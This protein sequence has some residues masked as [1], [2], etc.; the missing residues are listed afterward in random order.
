MPDANPSVTEKSEEL[1]K[2]EDAAAIAKVLKGK[3]D[4]DKAAA[5]AIN[6]KIKAEKEREK[7]EAT[8]GLGLLQAQA[9]AIAKLLPKGEAKPL[10]GKVETKDVGGVA[11]LVAFHVIRNIAVNIAAELGVKLGNG[12]KKVMIV[13]QLDFASG[14]LPLIEIMSQLDQFERLL[15]SQI[16][17]NK[18]I[19]KPAPPATGAKKSLA[20]LP[21]FSPATEIVAMAGTIIPGLANLIGYFKTDYTVTGYEFELDKEALAAGVAGALAKEQT[22]VYFY[23]FYNIENVQTLPVIQKLIQLGNLSLDL[24][25]LKADLISKKNQSDPGAKI[26]ELEQALKESQALLDVIKTYIQSINTK[27]TG[28]DC[29]KLVRAALRDRMH[30]LGITHLLYLNILPKS[31]GESIVKRSI[32]RSTE[33]VGYLGGAAAS[34]VLAEKGGKIIASDLRTGLSLYNYLLAVPEKSCMTSIPFD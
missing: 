25:H 5:V 26:T 12:I 8:S 27:A 17:E 24:E 6:E 29:S 22:E 10:E 14:D 34:Y 33:A 31:G 4:D 23:N 20:P 3:A 7:L 21:A 18:K 30:Q 11:R 16:E 19:L 32:W 13:P 2:A 15:T 1:K 28:E 9:E